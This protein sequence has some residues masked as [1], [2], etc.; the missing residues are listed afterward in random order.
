MVVLTAEMG[1]KVLVQ[2]TVAEQTNE[3]MVETGDGE[4]VPS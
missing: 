4:E 3:V 2:D 1:T